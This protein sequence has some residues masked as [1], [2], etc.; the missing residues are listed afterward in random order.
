[1]PWKEVDIVNLREEFVFKSMSSAMS[2]TDL[3]NEYNIS[4]KTGYKWIKRFKEQGLYGLK[5]ESRK[6]KSTPGSLTEDVSCE[7]IRIKH[8]CRK[9]WGPKKVQAIYARRFGEENTP[10]VSSVKR[11]L[12][13]AGFVNHRRR[14]RADP[15]ASIKNRVEPDEPNQVWT[16]DFKGWWKTRDGTRCEPLTIRDEYS[17]FILCLK[18]FEDTK[19]KHVRSSFENLFGLYGLPEMIRS[20]NGSPFANSFSP[21]G[22]TKLSA[23]WVSLGVQLDRIT[24]GR[25]DQNGAHERM[26]KDIYEDLEC[27]PSLNLENSQAA[28]DEWRKEFNW[29]RPHERINMKFPGEIYTASSAKYNP[30]PSDIVYPANWQERRITSTGTIWLS[31]AP[32]FITNSL[33]GYVVGLQ[34]AGDHLDVWFDNLMLGSIDLKLMKF[35]AIR[36]KSRKRRS[37]G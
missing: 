8:N 23:W 6:P 35:N 16:V 9:S 26:H 7:L 28:F 1:M 5:N 3:C 22:L 19:T 21:L 32:I 18:V 13:K 25:P 31:S 33:A 37:K 10:S 29:Q 20:D 11:V 27:S 12:D 2:V 30:E 34:A 15:P 17:R 24:P 4:R 36:G 14:K